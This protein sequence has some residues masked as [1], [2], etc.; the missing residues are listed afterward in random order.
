MHWKEALP[1]ILQTLV[2][3][4]RLG[5]ITD[6]DGTLSHIVPDPAQARISSRSREALRELGATLPVVAVV[7]GRS[8]GDVRSLVGIPGLVYIGNHG[9]E[10]WAGDRVEV[11]PEVLA[12]RPALEAALHG[13]RPKLDSGMQL[14][15]KGA[16][17]SIH[18]RSVSDPKSAAD[19]FRPF[20]RGIAEKHGLTLSQGRMVFELRPPVDVNKGS[21][22]HHLIV[23]YRL[24]AALYM[25]DD[26]TDLDAFQL[27]RR[28]REEGSCFALSVGVESEEMPEALGHSVDMVA[29]GVSDVEALLSWLAEARKASSI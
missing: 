8:V 17:L 13:I 10:Y 18:Y 15:D 28:L 1:T 22:F 29:S 20:L 7:S 4:D 6:F 14:E 16:T 2:E 5:L 12:F 27:A 3:K 19:T 26:V 25:G 24:E 9:M 21:A 11:A 23:A